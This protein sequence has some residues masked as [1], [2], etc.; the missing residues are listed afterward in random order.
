MPIWTDMGKVSIPRSL[1]LILQ[2]HIESDRQMAFVSGP[3]QVGKTTLCRNLADH[4]L[5]WDND[6]HRDLILAGPS[7]VAGRLSLN[8]LR[9]TRTILALDEIH[10]YSK[11]KTFLKGFFDTYNEVCGTLVTGSSRLDVFKKG[12]DSMMGRYFSYR[13]HPL[14]ISEIITAAFPKKLLRAPRPVNEADFQALW[15]FGGF[16]E[17]YL[18]RDRRFSVRW[19]RLRNE[20]LFR[21]DVRELTRIQELGQ[22]ETLGRILA[23]RSGKQIIHSRLANEVRVEDKT[24]RSWIT[25]LSSFH[26]GFLIQPWHRNVS[27]SLRKEPKW[28]LRDWAGISDAGARTETF[29]ACHLLKAV[30]GWSDLGLGNF[31]LCYIRDK[32]KREVDFIVIRDDEPWFLVEAKTARTKISSNLGYFQRATGCQHAFQAT[33]DMAFVDIDCF[34]TNDPVIVPA[35]TLLSQLTL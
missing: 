9:T 12:G 19:N 18:K 34:E 22:L 6:N 31:E 3:R 7:V 4:Y 24:I 8:E 10:K 21:E 5:D 26:F 17:P 27:R 15:Q 33:L 13:M 20:Q 23:S 16:P 30:E 11:W 28:Y 35:R 14:G 2:G 32:E 29:I 25:T 1:G